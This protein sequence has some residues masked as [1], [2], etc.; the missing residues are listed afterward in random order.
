MISRRSSRVAFTGLLGFVLVACSA[1]LGFDDRLGAPAAPGVDGSQPPVDVVD[2]Q[3]PI[4]APSDVI[5]IDSPTGVAVVVS[6]SQ[7]P[8]SFGASVT[9]TAI[10]AGNTAIPTG[11]VTFTDGAAALGKI[12]LE[13]KDAFSRALFTTSALSAGMHTIT[14]TYDGDSR[15]SAGSAGS[16]VIDVKQATTTTTLAST[17]NPASADQNITFTATVST[18]L[19]GP[20]D[21]NVSFKEGAT[22]LGTVPLS[23]GTAVLTLPLA[24]GFHPVVATYEGTA[25]IGTSSSSVVSQA[26]T[27]PG[28]QGVAAS[29]GAGGNVSCCASATVPGGTFSR[30]Y[31]GVTYNIATNTAT[32]SAF[33]LD[34]F[35]ITVSRYRAFVM[36]GKG[37]QAS[38]PAAGDG[39][40]P[41]IASS[42]WNSAYDALLPVDT[43]ALTT[44]VTVGCT[45]PGA[46]AHTWTDLPGANELKPMNCLNWYDVFAFCAWDGGRLPT[47]AEWNFA[48]AAGSQQRVRP[49]SVPASSTFIDPVYAVYN[50]AGPL[51]VGAK[52]LGNG[53]WGHSD[54]SGNVWEWALDYG[55]GYPNPCVDC[56]NLTTNANRIFR[57]GGYAYNEFDTTASRRG[58]GG[59][60]FRGHDVGGRC[61]RAP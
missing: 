5:V 43:A 4:D 44:A 29:C 46:G 3:A 30:S 11:T 24:G 39:A 32:V 7:N 12:A 13:P 50:Q 27:G 10:A 19:A 31:D 45:F 37:T 21:G 51:V 22:T 25:N 56:A 40:H 54:L 8:S 9:F 33:A 58:T 15:Y 52:P 35:E 28:C 60:G 42:G 57:G 20:I 2:S 53:L 41:L 18:T 34:R 59:P 26:M 55:G 14:A 61:A 6:A 49:Y 17:P 47:E 1:V 36:A 16:S 38:P 23:S 48:A